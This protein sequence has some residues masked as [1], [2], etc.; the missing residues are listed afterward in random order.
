MKQRPPNDLWGAADALQRRGQMADAAN[1]LR[2]G[3]CVQTLLRDANAFSNIGVLLK[4]MYELT[5]DRNAVVSL[6]QE[7][8]RCYST[9]CRLDRSQALHRYRLGNTL[10]ELRDYPRSIA[11]YSRAVSLFPK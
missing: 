3:V 2:G 4:Q 1:V 7:A 6:L 9:A 10:M 11:A 5:P 8:V